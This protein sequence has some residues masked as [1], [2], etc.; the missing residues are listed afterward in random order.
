MTARVTRLLDW[1]LL[2]AV[3]GFLMWIVFGGAAQAGDPKEEARAI[4]NAGNAAARR[5]L[6]RLRGERER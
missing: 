5:H 3:C 2:A 6:R 1:T 4:G